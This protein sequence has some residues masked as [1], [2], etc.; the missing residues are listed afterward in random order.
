MKLFCSRCLYKAPEEG[1]AITEGGLDTPCLA[2]TVLQL[3]K[4]VWPNIFNSDKS[5]QSKEEVEY[6]IGI[7]VK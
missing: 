1:G 7:E 4:P 5:K 2:N 6:L 3:L